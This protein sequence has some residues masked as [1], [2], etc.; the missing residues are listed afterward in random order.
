MIIYSINTYFK[1]TWK[2]WIYASIVLFLAFLVLKY[3]GPEEFLKPGEKIG[4]WDYLFSSLSYPF[5]NLLVIPTC[6]CYLVSDIVSKDYAEGYINFILTRSPNRLKYFL[7]KVIIIFLTSNLF[8][9]LCIFILIFIS[10]IY[11]MPI[12]NDNY[13]YVVRAVME[14]GGS[15]VGLFMTQ[16]VLL[17]LEL[18]FLGIF[19][20]VIALFFNKSIYSFIGLFILI[21]QGHN[22]IFNNSNN[23]LLSP[24]A[25]GCLSLHVPY[26]AYEI[27]REVNSIM[28]KF[29]VN[30][31]IIF[32]NML[33]LICCIIGCFKIRTTNIHTKRVI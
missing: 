25:Q 10:F 9:L 8:Y 17:T 18:E 29:T 32:L 15:I 30:Y 11:Q 24:L 33:I 19:T 4:L 3:I 7:S 23:R 28:A 26:Y 6:Y 12:Q 31:S 2:R 22:A 14:S 20:V 5:L 27:G 13:Y 21:I 16:Y 1:T